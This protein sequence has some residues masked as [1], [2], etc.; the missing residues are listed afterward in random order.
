MKWDVFA[1]HDH[2]QKDWVR[3]IVKEWRDKELRVFFDEDSIG[4][5]E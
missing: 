1:S 2:K 4:P 5:G 3:N